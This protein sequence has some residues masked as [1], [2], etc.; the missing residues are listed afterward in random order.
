MKYEQI[1]NA[2]I[3]GLNSNIRKSS[4]KEVKLFFGTYDPNVEIQAHGVLEFETIKEKKEFDIE[5]YDVCAI[6]I[7]HKC[8]MNN[9]ETKAYSLWD[10]IDYVGTFG[11]YIQV[12]DGTYTREFEKATD[13]KE[14]AEADDEW[15]SEL[16]SEKN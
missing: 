16:L 5:E 9:E 1:Q 14:R 10:C 8:Y 2:I 15:L 12:G 11:G 4:G 6:G 3:K 13:L 7:F